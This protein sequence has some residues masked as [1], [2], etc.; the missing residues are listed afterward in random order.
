MLE[1]MLLNL[2]H[3]IQKN[4]TED[5]AIIMCWEVKEC[6]LEFLRADFAPKIPSHMKV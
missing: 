5:N 1:D 6:K 2:S 4:I 3:P